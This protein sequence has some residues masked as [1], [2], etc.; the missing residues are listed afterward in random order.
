MFE[1]FIFILLIICHGDL[2]WFPEISSKP[3]R[4]NFFGWSSF[5][6]VVHSQPS[7]SALCSPSPGGTPGS[8]LI[9]STTCGPKRTE[10]WVL[11]TDQR[12]SV[13]PIAPAVM[14]IWPQF[15]FLMENYVV[16]VE[17]PV[18]HSCTIK[19]NQARHWFIRDFPVPCISESYGL[20]YW[21]LN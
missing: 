8:L 7:A 9:L 14:A 4:G 17:E 2:S 16:V 15:S 3:L 5:C 6:S 19:V 21:K 10:L 20:P 13:V 11:S 12:W 18:A 1:Y